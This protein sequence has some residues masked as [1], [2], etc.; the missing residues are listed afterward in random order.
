[1]TSHVFAYPKVSQVVSAPSAHGAD[2][3][4]PAPRPAAR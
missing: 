1:M 4:R 2:Q 3:L